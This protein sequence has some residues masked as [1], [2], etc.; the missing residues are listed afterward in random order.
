[1]GFT[2]WAGLFIA[3]GQQNSSGR[4]PALKSPMLN[5]TFDSRDS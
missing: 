3:E 4:L 2:F 1:M 5:I